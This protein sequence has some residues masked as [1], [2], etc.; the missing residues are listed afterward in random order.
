MAQQEQTAEE[1]LRAY[2]AGRDRWT[3]V[4]TDQ[5]WHVVRDQAGILRARNRDPRVVLETLERRR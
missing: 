5:G 4:V 1:Q 2:V 3:H